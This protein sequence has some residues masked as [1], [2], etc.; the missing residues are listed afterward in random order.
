MTEKYTNRLRRL[1]QLTL[2][3]TVGLL[4][5]CSADINVRGN[6]PDAD[7]LALIKPGA[8]S[9]EQVIQ[10]LGS[11]TT[12]ST[13]DKT[14]IYYISQRTKVVTFNKPKVLSRNII[15]IHFDKKG[16]V[17]KIKNYDLSNSRDIALI[18]RTTPTP[19]RQFTV[20]QQ[21]LGNFGRFENS[22]KTDDQ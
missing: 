10:L 2:L 16:R 13:F 18:E 12:I 6:A 8:Q 9:R 15:E 19:G 3:A 22:G 7:R 1:G 21:L 17:A 5:G 4:V 20:L 11:P 14:T